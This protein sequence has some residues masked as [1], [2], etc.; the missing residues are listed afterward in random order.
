MKVLYHK[1]NMKEVKFGADWRKTLPDIEDIE[2][3]WP[4]VSEE[5]REFMRRM[6]ETRTPEALD[7]K[8]I[9][10]LDVQGMPSAEMRELYEDQK[11][12]LEELFGTPDTGF[13][14]DMFFHGTGKEKYAREKY[15]GESLDP[16][17]QA[18]AG[19]AGVE[20]KGTPDGHNDADEQA[21]TL[22]ILERVLQDGLTPHLDIWHPT[23]DA[24]SV[25]LTESYFYSKWY[26]AKYMS[27][28]N[29]PEWQL[30]NPN[31][32]FPFF[33]YDSFKREFGEPKNWPETLKRI[34]ESGAEMEKVRKQREAS[35]QARPDRFGN[36]LT[37]FAKSGG[38]LKGFNQ[39]LDMKSDIPDNWG[40]VICIEKKGVNSDSDMLVL[41]VH[42]SRAYEVI[43]PSQFKAI[44]VP[45]VHMDEVRVMLEER[46]LSAVKVIAMEA[47]ELHMAQ[48][49]MKDLVGRS[50]GR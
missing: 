3:K 7:Q 15:A 13:K 34:F 30:G 20:E 41:G 50:E 27:E 48:F 44:A 1:A 23:K 33:I 2:A 47:A 19:E 35:G 38:E 10:F 43:D 45:A 21:K 31:D 18:D 16:E 14:R 26:A 39:Q 49:E 24:E 12:D 29:E 36:W 5:N 42:E 37:S 9:E 4:T 25:S 28:G 32:Y 17:A 8:V 22:P 46:G 40:A 11:P 6:W